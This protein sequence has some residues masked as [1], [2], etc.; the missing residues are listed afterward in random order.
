MPGNKTISPGWYAAM[1]FI[2]ATLAWACFF[3]L[4]RNIMK[5]IL[6]GGN[7]LLK[8]YK[9]WR[10]PFLIPIFWLVLYMIGGSY[11]SLYKKSRLT[12]FSSTLFYSIIG[13]AILLLL[14]PHGT[15]LT[16]TGY[17]FKAFILLLV[18]HFAIT[19]SGRALILNIV[20]KQLLEGKIRFNTLMVGNPVSVRS[21]YLKTKKNLANG[22]YRYIGFISTIQKVESE[23]A[24]SIPLLGSIDEMEKIIDERDVRQVVL[25]L[26]KPEQALVE[27]ILS[28]LGEKDVEIKIRPDT[29]DIL[30]GSVKT[31]NI[32][33]AVLIDLNTDMLPE[34]QQ[35]LKRLIDIIVSITGFIIL[36]PLILYV[37]IRIK[38]SSAGPVFYKQERI[39]YKGRPFHIYKFRSMLVNAEENGPSLSS[40]ND[41]RITKWGR[42]MRKWRLDELPQLW[43]ILIG[44]MSL[45]GPR[46]ERKF[47]IDR[48]IPRFPYYKYLLKVK[49]GL[50]SWGMV[51]FGYAEN[52]EEMIERSKFDLV[53][54]ENISLLLDFKIMIHTIRIILLGKGK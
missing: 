26:E 25:A 18:L 29:L 5:E 14:L 32:L 1:D 53:Y 46:P 40:D 17:F 20:K 27:N 24:G 33:G 6:P 21:I 15:T 11:S 31:N 9:F 41:P 50:T 19:F 35:N 4:Y 28:R 37:F 52:E 34:W 23:I 7:F 3:F 12:E 54:L 42:V 30:S 38:L 13:C 8:G 47:Y 16:N 36:S 48:I 45:V 51:Q 44:E 49:P 10:G 39:G 22:G 43:N 2:T